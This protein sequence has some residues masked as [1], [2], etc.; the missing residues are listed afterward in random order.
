MAANHSCANRNR[1]NEI[2]C[3]R[4]RETV[5]LVNCSFVISGLPWLLDSSGQLPIILKPISVTCDAPLVQFK[6][7]WLLMS[8]MP[9][10]LRYWGVKQGPPGAESVKSCT[11]WPN[12]GIAIRPY[13]LWNGHK[14]WLTLVLLVWLNS[15]LSNHFLSTTILPVVLIRCRIPLASRS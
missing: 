14:K 15:S 2:C 1:E 3:T 7:A 8:E 12:A 4:A 9:F 6:T 13:P 5:A 11:A 10:W